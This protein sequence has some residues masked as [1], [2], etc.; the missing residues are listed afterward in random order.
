MTDLPHLPEIFRKLRRGYH[1]TPADG[2]PYR[3]LEDQFEAYQAAFDAFGLQLKR[4]RQQTV[5]LEATPSQTPGT[6]ARTMGLFMLI[7]IEWFGTQRASLV[8]DLFERTFRLDDLPHLDTERYR[9]AMKAVGVQE[10]A[11]LESIVGKLE[12]FGFARQTSDGFRLRAAAYRFLDLCQEAIEQ[13][14]AAE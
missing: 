13:A 5:Y 9:E 10:R 14:E 7:L 11:G 3:A 2:A 12:Q 4:H 8:P 1:Y 6:E